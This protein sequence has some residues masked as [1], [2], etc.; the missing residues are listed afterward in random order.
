MNKLGTM[1]IEQEKINEQPGILFCFFQI[2]KGLLL[3]NDQRL[4]YTLLSSRFFLQTFG[5][6]EWDPDALMTGDCDIN[7]MGE[8]SPL[9]IAPNQQNL[10]LLIINKQHFELYSKDAEQVEWLLEFKENN[11]LT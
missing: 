2:Y 1:F 5:A 3:I 11:R 4:T 6:L 9:V 7:E 8:M 10:E